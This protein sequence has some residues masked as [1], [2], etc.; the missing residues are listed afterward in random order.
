MPTDTIVKHTS[1][2]WR[3]DE[4]YGIPSIIAHAYPKGATCV[5]IVYSANGDNLQLLSRVPPAPDDATIANA[6]LIAA[7]P[8]LLAA[9]KAM[10][11]SYDGLRDAVSG[12]VVRA[13]LAAADAA[14]A[15]AEGQ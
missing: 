1:G 9:L 11:A 8:D 7:A 14:L 4:S 3:V 2:P 12:E 5:A 6:R 15:K 10:V 13:K